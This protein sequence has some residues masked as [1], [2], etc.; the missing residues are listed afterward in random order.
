MKPNKPV[1]IS[2]E[3]AGKIHISTKNNAMCGGKIGFVFSVDWGNH[4]KMF[5][6]GRLAN[7]EAKKLAEHI[8]NVIKENEPN[9]NSQST[10]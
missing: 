6:G 1:E 7:E 5:R 2:V 3:G 10:T 9:N 8:L 4:V